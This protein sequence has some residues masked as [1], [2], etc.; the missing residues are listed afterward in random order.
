MRKMYSYFS[1]LPLEAVFYYGGN[2]CIK[3]SS[4]TALYVEYNRRFYFG[5]M[6]VVTV[7]VH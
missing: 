6:E 1:E 7:L 4:R 5:R 2:Q 3:T